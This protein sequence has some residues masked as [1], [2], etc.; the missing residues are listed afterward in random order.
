MIRHD[1]TRDRVA[2]RN[3]LRV[4]EQQELDALDLRPSRPAPQRPRRHKR[5]RSRTTDRRR[6]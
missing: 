1:P 6:N 3:A 2:T 4:I 5:K